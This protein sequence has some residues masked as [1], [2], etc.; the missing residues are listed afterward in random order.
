[1]DVAIVVVVVVEV[2]NSPLCIMYIWWI[3]RYASNVVEHHGLFLRGSWRSAISYCLLIWKVDLALPFWIVYATKAPCS[4]KPC[5]TR[6]VFFCSIVFSLV[7][8]VHFGDRFF[9]E[10]L[11]SYELC[12]GPAS[13]C[14]HA[15]VTKTDLRF[16]LWEFL[17]LM[18]FLRDSLLC[19]L[20]PGGWCDFCNAGFTSQSTNA[21]HLW[22][23]FFFTVFVWVFR[24]DFRWVSEF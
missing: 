22:G 8:S 9:I 17:L 23:F 5:N 12:K 11:I 7:K 2:G 16:C 21:M 24:I 4:T 1:M 6:G 18:V 13:V 14:M 20:A 19:S 15:T 3:N 10:R